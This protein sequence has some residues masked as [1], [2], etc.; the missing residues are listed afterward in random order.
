MVGVRV[1]S[2]AYLSPYAKSRDTILL[3]SLPISLVVLR[4]NGAGASLYWAF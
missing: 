3:L 4:V 1:F 2:R